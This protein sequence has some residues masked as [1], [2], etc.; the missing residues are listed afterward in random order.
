MIPQVMDQNT[1]KD[2]VIGST[3]IFVSDIL[4]GADQATPFWKPIYCDSDGLTT[5]LGL[6]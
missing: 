5:R 3:R 2:E 6:L 4:R 1:L